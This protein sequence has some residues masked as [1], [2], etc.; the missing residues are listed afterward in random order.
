MSTPNMKSFCVAVVQPYIR[1]VIDFFQS[2]IKYI[3]G[4]QAI[5][6]D[7]IA[8]VINSNKQTVTRVE[9][10]EAQV[11]QMSDDLQQM[12][13]DF[14]EASDFASLEEIKST[15]TQHTTE[16]KELQDGL[17]DVPNDL[18]ALEK[19]VTAN[20]T[21][22]ST[23]AKNITAVNNSVTTVSST[24]KTNNENFEAAMDAIRE[25]TLFDP[26]DPVVIGSI[27]WNSTKYKPYTNSYNKDG[28]QTQTA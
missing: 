18:A 17:A 11:S 10:A 24:V 5:Q 1:S 21:S 16:I 8:E 12:R 13:K 20:T 26:I 19:K 4:K 25:C 6:D 14:D 3:E 28:K 23:N 2:A 15:V 27:T 7:K 22:I 9:E